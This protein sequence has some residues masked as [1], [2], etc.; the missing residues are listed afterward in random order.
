MGE[1]VLSDGCTITGVIDWGNAI[2]GDPLYDVASV[3]LWLP[4]T[5][6]RFR[7]LYA[8]Q[9]REVPRFAERVACYRYCQLLDD[10]RFNAFADRPNA[11]AEAR[12]Q[13]LAQLDAER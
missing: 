7:R 12:A 4:D 13:L 9:G 6:E 1:N 11:Y 2:Y 10:L 3:D 5:S 8:E